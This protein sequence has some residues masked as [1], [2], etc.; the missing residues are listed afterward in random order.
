ME[1]KESKLQKHD[2]DDKMSRDDSM[3]IIKYEVRDKINAFKMKIP[4]KNR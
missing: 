3:I 2:G 1:C 4:K